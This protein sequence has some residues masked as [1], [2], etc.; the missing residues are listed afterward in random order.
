MMAGKPAKTP[1]TPDPTGL[2]VSAATE[3]SIT[4]EWNSGGGTTAGFIVA[5]LE[6]T[7]YPKSNLRGATVIEG[8]TTEYH[9]VPG[10]KTDQVY[11]F[12]VCAVDSSGKR[13]G[14]VTVQGSTLSAPPVVYEAVDYY[15]QFQGGP[16]Y[17][18]KWYFGEGSFA[19][20][21]DGKV[22]VLARGAPEPALGTTGDHFICRMNP[23]GTADTTFNGSG[24]HRMD[25]LNDGD[26]SFDFPQSVIVLLDEFGETDKILVVGTTGG[27]DYFKCRAVK[28]LERTSWSLRIWCLGVRKR[29]FS[30]VGTV[31]KALR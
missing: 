4:L 30:A 13:S 8:I 18:D 6:G 1:P 20:Q 29:R 23:D 14:G 11:S 19:V 7:T 25:I 27:L 31:R 12:R 16:A 5:Y 3:D 24:F 21:P 9:T 26:L 15:A 28:K 17:L 22:L 10:L 2:V